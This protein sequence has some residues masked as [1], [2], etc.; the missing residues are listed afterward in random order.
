[1]SSS[2]KGW[3]LSY[4]CTPSSSYGAPHANDFLLNAVVVTT[5]SPNAKRWTTSS[6]TR[7]ARGPCRMPANPTMLLTTLTNN[8]SRLVV[9]ICCGL[10]FD[11]C[12]R[13]TI[14]CEAWGHDLRSEAC[15]EVRQRMTHYDD[16]LYI[17]TKKNKAAAA[18]C[19]PF[20]RS[21]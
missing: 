15:Q 9:A 13:L 11:E 18:S 5:V 20:L 2:D 10:L 16:M 21:R 7:V 1:V 8:T 3:V 12:G 17:S 14:A 19:Y 4:R 6:S